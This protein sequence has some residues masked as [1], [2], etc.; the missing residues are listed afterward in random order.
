MASRWTLACLPLV[1]LISVVWPVAAEEKPIGDAWSDARNPVVA[2][3]KGQRLDLWS[4]KPPQRK[5]PPSL[6]NAAKVHN[7]IDRFIRAKLEAAR[8]TPSP[9]A[10]RKTLIRRLTFGLIGL[11]PTPED[12][13]DFLDDSRPDAYERLVDRLLAS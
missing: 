4:L 5:A 6:Q 8:L 7:P 3:F 10:D 1:L 2:R 9:E 12:V 13:R 11:P